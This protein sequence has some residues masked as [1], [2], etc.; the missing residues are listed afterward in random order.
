MML[1]FTKQISE[2]EGN[3]YKGN[4]LFIKKKKLLF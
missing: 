3:H 4:P 2:G 1:L